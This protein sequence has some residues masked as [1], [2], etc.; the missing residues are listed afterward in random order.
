M[1]STFKFL[2][3]IGLF[4]IGTHSA[5]AACGD[6]IAGGTGTSI[7]PYQI[8]TPTELAAI[9]NCLGAGNASKYFKVM[10][11]IDLNVAP[12]NTGSGW[13]PI[14]S[15]GSS[16]Y[17]KF[18]GNGQT[19]SNLFIDRT[20]TADV[21][22]FGN[23]SSG[24]LI[25]NIKLSNIN[26]SGGGSN[27]G[28]LAGYLA[29]VVRYSS[30]TG[31]SIN[32]LTR[33]GGLI[34]SNR[35]S[36]QK[37]SSSGVTI[38]QRAAISDCCV[39]G[40][41]GAT[42]FTGSISDSYARSN[43]VHTS[44][45][46]GVF[47]GAI[48]STF[49][50]S[51][52]SNVYSTGTV[53]TLTSYPVQVGGLVGNGGIAA[54]SSY[55]DTQTSGQ[56]TSGTGTGKT[57]SEMKTQ[58]TFTGWDFTNI[59]G[60]SGGTN[61]GYPYLLPYVEDVIAP[62]VSTLSPADNATAAS[63]NDNLTITFSEP[64]NKGTGNITIY[65][66]GDNSIVEAINVTSGQVTGAGTAT[67]SINPSADLEMGESYYVQISSTA[68]VDVSDN[69]NAY[70]GIS[71]LS[72]WNF[73]T[74]IY[75]IPT[76]VYPTDG[77][78][79][80]SLYMDMT[81]N[82]P[83][84]AGTLKITLTGS[85]TYTLTLNNLSVGQHILT[86]P[87]NNALLA[88]DV[89]S[90]SPSSAIAD[91]VYTLTLSHRDATNTSTLST[92]PI[93]VTVDTVAPTVTTLSPADNATGINLNPS[94]VMTF[95]EAVIKHSGTATLYK[96]SDNSVIETIN[97]INPA[98]SGNET[99]TMSIQPSVNLL[100]NTGYYILVDTGAFTDLVGN[101]YAGI[102]NTTAWNFTTGNYVAPVLTTVTPIQSFT[103]IANARYIF[104]TSKVCQP[105]AAA[106]I[107]SLVGDT[108]ET[109]ITAPVPDS[110]LVA[111]FSGIQV[112]GTYSV[113]FQCTDSDL[114]N[115][116]TITVGPFTV[117]APSNSSSSGYSSTLAWTPSKT[118]PAVDTK[119]VCS[120]D[121]LL[122]QNLKAG[123][124][125]GIYNS[126]T[127]GIVKEVKI[128]QAHMNRLGFNAGVVD[129]I[130]GKLT[131]GAIKRMQKFLGT[132]Q[133]GLIGPVTRGLI[134]NSCGNNGIGA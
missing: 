52:M 119:K 2:F 60:I 75:Q 12:Y 19:I 41:T 116:N 95:N 17:G 55:W 131:D 115:S 91:G 96:T 76:M 93:S 88:S 53:T 14:G 31:G 69:A 38:T 26:I 42:E 5:L 111:T 72:A 45:G 3:I 105:L 58:G 78:R 99:T 35:G 50:A 54:T 59:W 28:G 81:I 20:S 128:L 106:P 120:A 21:G 34:G 64:V 129:G 9:S 71:N 114:N 122:T 43:V 83:V 18:N 130:L 100:A 77:Q 4:F 48:G 15:S 40:L 102:S 7:D 46:Q 94:F 22:L 27:V 126:Y 10:Q 133:D 6:S 24:G 85:T 107:S 16:F 123:A 118:V 98:I 92:V 62:T 44:S 101:Q 39:G 33:L 82:E 104:R 57:T 124:R 51:S 70:S 47:G 32:G 90:A 11:D 68:F 65:K 113:E 56:A 29:G 97:V 13:S 127:K 108:V 49:N 87:F 61:N 73:T 79:M 109:I 63:I 89:V 25:H 117:I 110:D 132:G 37:S 121:Q 134:N 23:V 86:I 1:K 84:F 67:I 66:V 36:V 80:T 112:G 103:T 125:N 8:D 74:G 30:V